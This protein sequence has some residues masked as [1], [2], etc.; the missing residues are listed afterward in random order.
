MTDSGGQPQFHLTPG[1]TA[2]STEDGLMY[3][4]AVNA[5][6]ANEQQQLIVTSGDSGHDDAAVVL[7]SESADTT[8][9]AQAFID[10]GG[11]VPVLFGKTQITTFVPLI[12]DAWHNITLDAGWTS[13]VTPQYRL[14][15]DGDVE[16]RGQITHAGVTVA[17]NI[18]NSNP[19]PAA[20]RPP[21]TRVYRPPTAGDSAGTVGITTA[22]VLVMR[23]SGFTATA[24]FLDGSYSLA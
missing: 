18:N 7:N 24:A 20:Y 11:T 1:G 10:L 8:V 23:A 6:A 3:I 13:V 9:A 21:A 14:K 15:P 19:L 2:H 22:G 17:T 12:A 5:G 16:V 4:S